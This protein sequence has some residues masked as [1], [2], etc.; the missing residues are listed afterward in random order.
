MT[1]AGAGGPRVVTGLARG[2]IT[3]D[4]LVVPVI[5]MWLADG[6]LVL[7]AAVDG[8]VRAVDTRDYRVHDRSGGLVFW[9][10]AVGGLVW[11]AVPSGMRLVV[12]CPV[13]IAGKTAQGVDPPVG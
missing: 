12:E 1:S 2:S 13:E 9:A 11:P 10:H 4:E 8:P 5:D 3:I 7:L 6:L